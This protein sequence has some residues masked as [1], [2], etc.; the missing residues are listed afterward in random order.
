MVAHVV[1]RYRRFASERVLDLEVPF[2]IFGVR[3]VVVSRR[4]GWGAEDTSISGGGGGGASQRS[5]GMETLHQGL[6]GN[7]GRPECAT[8][9]SG[10]AFESG[11]IVTGGGRGVGHE[12]FHDLC[13]VQCGNS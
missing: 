6:V 3:D 12:S 11:H 13:R 4:N 9:G 1:E 7:G 8:R 10:C 2:K 5:P